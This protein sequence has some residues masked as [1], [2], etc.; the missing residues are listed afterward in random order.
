MKTDLILARERANLAQTYK[1]RPVVIDHGLGARCVDVE[2]KSYIDFTSGIGVNALGYCDP[3][4]VDAVTRQLH[5]LQHACNLYYTEPM[6]DA[7]EMLTRRTCLSRVFFA[8]SGAEANEG[9]IKA[10]R[11]YGYDK[12][13]KA[14]T[15][16]VTLKNS[17][18]GRTVTTVSATGQDAFHDFFFPFTQGFVYAPANDLAGTLA[19]LDEHVCAVML[20]MVQGEGGVVPLEKAYVQGLQAACRERDILLIVDEVQTGMGRTGTL[21]SYEQFG[22]SPDIVTSAKGLGAGLPIGAV[23]LGEKV[24][25]TLGFG[26]HGTTFGGNP[27]ACAGACEVLR[28][29]DDAF[30]EAVVQKGNLLRARIEQMPGV[31]QV[32]G[33][34]MMLGIA[35]EGASALDVVGECER[36]GL[37]VLTAKQ[38]VRL[39]PPLQLDGQE[40]ETGLAILE[41]A[42]AA[43]RKKSD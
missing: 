27:V 7:A 13:G 10:A 40:L 38:K 41:S 20:E 3:G 17:F 15:T 39:L 29:M 37:L 2:G 31:K 25:D 18:H 35:L 34:G 22:V 5:K 19:C 6:I 30:L 8:N 16:I 11:K 36:R 4:W 14:H 28:R 33:L 42:I 12:L 21:F 9:A 43:A 24:K 26:Q 32:S 1:R 23:L